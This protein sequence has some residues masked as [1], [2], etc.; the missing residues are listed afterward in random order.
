M[1]LNLCKNII[2]LCQQKNKSIYMLEKE[3]GISNGSIKKWE[4]SYPSIDKALLVANNLGVTLDF[5]CTS[6]FYKK[7]NTLKLFIDKLLVQTINGSIQWSIIDN[8]SQDYNNLRNS[9]KLV[10][11]FDHEYYDENNYND[12]SRQEALSDDLIIYKCT[13]NK[14]NIFVIIQNIYICFNESLYKTYYYVSIEKNNISQIRKCS[15]ELISKLYEEIKKSFETPDEK[16]FNEFF[17]DFF[18]Q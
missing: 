13:K 14:I 5:L 7:S 3:I 10:T 1:N 12:P 8:K 17:N 2:A 4:K 16:E 6:D 9:N 11:N 18:N 15:K